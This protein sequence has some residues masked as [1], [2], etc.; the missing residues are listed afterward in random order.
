MHLVQCSQQGQC[1][2]WEE[3]VIEKKLFWKE[4]WAWELARQNFLMKSTYDTLPSPANLVRWKVSKES[5]CQCGGYGTLH[6]ILSACPMG[7]TDRYTWRHN[8]LLRVIVEAIEMKVTDINQAKLPVK[9]CQSKVMFY[10][11][12]KKGATKTSPKKQ[13]V[14]ER[15]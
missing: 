14:D 10:Q 7:L 1:L 5:K 2:R 13:V 8:Q 3:P 11:E 4:L 15:W 6:H 12:G 9:E